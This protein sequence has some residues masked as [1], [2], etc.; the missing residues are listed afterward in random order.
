MVEKIRGV[1]HLVSVVIFFSFIAAVIY[2]K[3]F[4]NPPIYSKE[5]F[6]VQSPVIFGNPMHLTADFCMDYP[7]EPLSVIRSA[8]NVETKRAY[9][10]A[11]TPTIFMPGCY[12][13]E[14]EFGLTNVPPGK[15]EYHFTATFQVNPIKN[16]RYTTKSAPFEI[17][18]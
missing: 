2:W 15:Y 3:W 18:K 12:A 8:V 1:W 6:Q 13:L 16:V 11:E 10:L 17:I 14:R 7:V 5:N 9:V 4:D